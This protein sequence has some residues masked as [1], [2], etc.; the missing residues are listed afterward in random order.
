VRLVIG[1][2]GV[3]RHGRADDVDAML[4]PA[5]GDVGGGW[6]VPERAETVLDRRYVLAAAGLLSHDFPT[7][8]AALLQRYLAG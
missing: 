4:A 8:A 1:S 7:A 5:V 6:Q 3:F 2:G